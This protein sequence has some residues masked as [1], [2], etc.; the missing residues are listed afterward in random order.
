[1]EIIDNNVIRFIGLKKKKDGL[2]AHF[3]VKG[4]KGGVDYMMT[5]SVD[6]IAANLDPSDSLERI[7][8]ESSKVAVK[9]I[10]QADFKFEGVTSAL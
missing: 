10:Q 4:T 6:V 9:Q 7:V 3:K 2:F 1:M 8:E 5:I